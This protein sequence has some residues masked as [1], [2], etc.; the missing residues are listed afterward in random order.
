MVKLISRADI[1]QYKQ[2]SKTVYDDVL[3]SFIIQ[4]QIQDIAPLLGE[5]L[6]NDIV[7]NPTNYNDLLN[8]GSYTV[9]A[10]TYQNYGLRAVISHYTYARYIMFGSVTD[11]PF[12]LVEKLN[13][14]SR[15]ASDS[16][17]KSIWQL[18]RDDAFGYWRSVENYLI[19]MKIPL[20]N[21]SNCNKQVAQG[22]F[23]LTKIV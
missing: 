6:F 17:K 11:T 7:N 22:G 8:G 18:S 3:D 10:N 20:Y 14:T 13:E 21:I 9:G 12:S 16:Q 19:R 1:A 23:R 15:P 2:I 4:A 5:M